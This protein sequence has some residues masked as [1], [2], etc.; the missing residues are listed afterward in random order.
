VL[1]KDLPVLY[2]YEG[3]SWQQNN[4]ARNRLQSGMASTY[5][6]NVLFTIMNEA[7]LL[8]RVLVTIDGDWI[9]Q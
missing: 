9:G 3:L 6:P 2:L 1:T 4:D 7:S 8:S 5:S